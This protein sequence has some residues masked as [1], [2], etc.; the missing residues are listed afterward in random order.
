[1]IESIK[2]MQPQVILLNIQMPVMNGIET[3]SVI[4]K[5]YPDIKVIILSGKIEE[6]LIFHSIEKGANCFLYK[7][8]EIKT[9]V[10]AI[11]SVTEKGYCFN[12]MVSKAM[13][14]GILYNKKN[15]LPMSS[16]SL[17]NREVDVVKL[18]C[19]QK[20]IKEIADTLCLSPRTIDTYR[21]NIFQ[22]TGAKNIVGVALYAIQHNLLDFQ[23]QNA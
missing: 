6:K 11:Y 9:L 23:L 7:D 22:K 13:M 15:T 19:K 21:E 2:Q 3:L 17:S 18:I 1:L 16:S 10:G 8:I 20:T 5:K 4:K 14:K 12:E